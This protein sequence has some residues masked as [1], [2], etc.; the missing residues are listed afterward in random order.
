[1]SRTPCRSADET[2]VASTQEQ[3]GAM[4]SASGHKP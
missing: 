4:A 1:L 3:L 2:F